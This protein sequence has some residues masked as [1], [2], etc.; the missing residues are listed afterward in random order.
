MIINNGAPIH[1]LKEIVLFPFDD[2]S[3]PFRNGVELQLVGK[4]T[5]CGSTKVVL[6]VGEP[7]SPDD[8]AVVY[9]GSVWKVGDEL[10]MWYLG[11]ANHEDCMFERICFARSKDGYNWEKPDLGLVE[12]NGSKHNNLVNLNHADC[13]V[14]TCT[15]LYEPN[16]TEEPFKMVY[17]RPKHPNR[18]TVAHSRDG[19]N[20]HEYPNQPIGLTLGTSGITKFNGCYHLAGQGG[21]HSPKEERQLVTWVSHDFQCWQQAS[22]MGL[23]R[24]N[25]PPRPTLSRQHEGEQV[26]LGAAL[27]NRGNVV[28]GFYGMWHGHPSNDRRL[29]TMD[30]GLAVSNDALHYREPI[31]DYPIVAAAED[32]WKELPLGHTGQPFAGLIQGQGFE[33]IADETLFW[34]APWPEMDS[35]GV[36]VAS[37]PRD[38]LGYL[39]SYF[40]CRLNFKGP[41]HVIS[42]P[43]DLEGKPAR[44]FLNVDDIDQYSKVSVA[45]LDEQFRPIPGYTH[46]ECLAPGSSGLREAVCWRDHQSIDSVGQK[47]RVR[48]DFDGVRQEDAK[49]YAVYL[50]EVC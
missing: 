22:C 8:R 17:D 50:E 34:Y 16:D 14:Q 44:M 30:L 29:L 43:I 18:L 12:Y 27:W 49:V 23:R 28:L 10:M 38:R 45:L 35:D 42:A 46:D 19:L 41:A 9:Y 36:R 1:S 6:P 39:R 11:Q 37:W 25:L 32:G 3:M 2:Y 4:E 5:P 15:V 47:I 21:N 13:H 48:L 7:G 31:P 20:W 24:H 40:T 33:N 26:H